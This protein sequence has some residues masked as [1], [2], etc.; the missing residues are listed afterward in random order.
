MIQ[1][2][3]NELAFIV[4]ALDEGTAKERR[5]AANFIE[6]KQAEAQQ[7]QLIAV[8][9]SQT[10]AIKEQGVKEYLDSLEKLKSK[11]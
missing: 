2:E 7:K 11:K 5:M 6:K 9:E 1:I 8:N 3:N 10:K 4:K